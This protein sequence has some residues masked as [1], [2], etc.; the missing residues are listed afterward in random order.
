MIVYRLDLNDLSVVATQDLRVRYVGPPGAAG[1]RTT[2]TATVNGPLWVAGGSTL[3]ALSPTTGAVLFKVPT[4]MAI[5]S[6]STSQDGT[7]LYTAGESN[8]YP[9]VLIELD[10]RTGRTLATEDESDSVAGGDVAATDH[11]VWV[12]FRTGLQGVTVQHDK[13]TLAIVTNQSESAGA[14]GY[15]PFDQG[16]GEAANVSDGALWLAGLQGLACA[17]PVTGALRVVEP[18]VPSSIE[19]VVAR[20]GV[21]Y[22]AGA[23]GLSVITAPRACFG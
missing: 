8:S 17:D 11:G 22:G 13:A 20:D 7:V 3:Y 2:L 23:G 18:S 9:L 4:E 15:S 6:L 10:A 21:L 14:V 5:F 19:S 1:V 12:S 16:M